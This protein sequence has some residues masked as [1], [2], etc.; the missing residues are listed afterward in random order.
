MV[1]LKQTTAEEVTLDIM[2]TV[3]LFCLNPTVAAILFRFVSQQ[4]YDIPVLLDPDVEGQEAHSGASI[5]IVSD[6]TFDWMLAMD[7]DQCAGIEA[8]V[9]EPFAS[10]LA[11]LDETAGI[12]SLESRY[13]EVFRATVPR[14]RW[15]RL[16]DLC[17][18]CHLLSLLLTKILP[19]A[20]DAIAPMPTEQ[21]RLSLVAHLA[22]VPP[23]TANARLRHGA[24]YRVRHGHV[25]C[26]LLGEGWYPAEIEHAWMCG[27]RAQIVLPLPR[28]ASEHTICRMQLQQLAATNYVR[29]FVDGVEALGFSITADAP[30]FRFIDVPLPS[31]GSASCVPTTIDF[32]CSA[33]WRPSDLDKNLVDRRSIGIGLR[34]VEFLDG[35]DVATAA[36]QHA[37]VWQIATG[38]PSHAPSCE[39]TITGLITAGC[40]GTFDASQMPGVLGDQHA[41]GCPLSLFIVADAT[42]IPVVSM[43]DPLPAHSK[44]FR[45]DL[46]GLAGLWPSMASA[47]SFL[48]AETFTQ[49]VACLDAIDADRV[50]GVDIVQVMESGG[51]PDESQRQWIANRFSRASYNPSHGWTLVH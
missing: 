47:P 21:A 12:S 2:G 43:P 37:C 14:A 11:F 42:T 16:P 13:A 3:A 41:R 27:A 48:R 33:A 46:A 1:S 29:V 51:G 32:V 6:K 15:L 30:P 50:M 25:G 39:P 5:V 36:L 44:V 4:N 24:I 22:E 31:S 23:G 26:L 40:A 7:C 10:I 20:T 35:V 45:G 18:S 28:P 49:A 19:G 38:E 34:S 9:V 8:W 17:M